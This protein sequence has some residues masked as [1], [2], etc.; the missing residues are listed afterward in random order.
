MTIIKSPVGLPGRA[1]PNAFIDDVNAGNRKPFKCSYHGIITCDV[2]KIPY[3]TL[4]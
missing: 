2:A 3:C 1:A 4:G